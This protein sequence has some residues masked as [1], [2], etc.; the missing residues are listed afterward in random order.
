MN[1]DLAKL[2]DLQAADNEI[3][4]IEAAL[5]DVPRRQADLGAELARES[6][7][8]SAVRERLEATQK[9]RRSN[10][11]ALQ[12]LQGRRSKYR[13]QLME[14]KTNR[15]YQAMLHEIEV[16]EREIHGIEDQILEDMEAGE[17]LA[18]EVKREQV[19]LSEAEKRHEQAVRELDVQAH[20]LQQERQRW[21][22]ERA[23]LA[24]SLPTELT[25]LYQRVARLRGAAV[26]EARAGTCQQ[27]R[28]VLRP[29]M[30]VELKRN[31]QIVQC[32]SCSRVLYYIPP[33]PTVDAHP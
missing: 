19:L 24:A 16:V 7:R 1:P 5:Q 12:D 11:G 22:D 28:M 25:E 14:V 17:G 30:Y 18:A 26:A 15:E 21:I 27:C 8:L 13:G 20:A 6:E 32:P 3:K 31:D 2:I 4:R 29:Q 23:G 9:R 10:E 33:P